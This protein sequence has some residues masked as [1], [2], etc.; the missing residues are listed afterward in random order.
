MIVVLFYSC[1]SS[2]HEEDLT[3]V[4]VPDVRLNKNDSALNFKKDGILYYKQEPFSGILSDY[5]ESGNLRSTCQFLEGKQHGLF[6]G[7]YPS[8]TNEFVRYYKKGEKHSVHRGWYAN[9]QLK[10]IYSFD[11][12]LS[13]G[14]H[15]VWYADGGKFQDFNFQ[16]GRA[17]GSQKVW[18]TDGKIRANYVVR[19][20]GRKYGLSGIKRCK[21]V[22]TQ[23]E[24]IKELTAEVYE[25]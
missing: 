10:F 25:K 5:Y 7:Y 11:N 15:K 12:G 21:N 17:L 6:E 16:N 4:E 8:G 1:H 18:R 9:G 24:Q 20:N 3:V 13:E 23:T 2:F 22:D 19:E 14:N